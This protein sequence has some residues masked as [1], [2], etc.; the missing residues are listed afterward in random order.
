MVIIYL[1][2]SYRYLINK[3]SKLIGY[4]NSHLCNG[5][6]NFINLLQISNKLIKIQT[7]YHM[8]NLYYNFA[9]KHF[10]Q[11]QMNM[12]YTTGQPLCWNC[13]SSEISENFCVFCKMIQPI[14]KE[15][16]YFD[17]LG[18]ESSFKIHRNELTKS[19]RKLQ[20]IFH[21]DKFSAKSEV[22]HD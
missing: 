19:Y 9:N 16:N 22:S 18:I 2:M 12:R 4:R 13:S 3:S 6:H 5:K 20:N 7:L 21:P 11:V 14:D 1:K 10:K 17:I 15:L 8:C